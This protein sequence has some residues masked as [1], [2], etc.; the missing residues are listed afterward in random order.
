MSA[1]LEVENLSK[2]FVTRSG[3]FKRRVQQAV[4]PVS[5]TLEAGQTIGAP[6]LRHA[7]QTD[8]DDFPRSQYLIES[9]Y[10]NRAYFGRSTQAKH[11]HATRST[12][13]AC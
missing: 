8:S 5:F 2:N 13:K 3:L 4:K 10:S 12:P 11:Q 6:R 1:L 7:L 9:T